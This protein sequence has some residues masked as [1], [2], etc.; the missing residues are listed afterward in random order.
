MCF[1]GWI[2]WSVVC[3][4]SVT[5]LLVNFN[6]I[7]LLLDFGIFKC[8]YPRFFY[9]SC[10]TGIYFFGKIKILFPLYLW[11]SWTKLQ[12]ARRKLI[13]FLFPVLYT[14]CWPKKTELNYIFTP[15]YPICY[16][17]INKIPTHRQRHVTKVTDTNI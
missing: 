3:F 17:H 6:S 5:S 10:S 12:S 11:L 7:F 15:N 1:S 2:F 4:V 9:I 16:A 8:M 14:I 13:V